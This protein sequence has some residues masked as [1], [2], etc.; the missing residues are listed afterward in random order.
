MRR[1][2]PELDGV[3][4]ALD[5]GRKTGFALGEPGACPVL[6]TITLSREFDIP[7][8]VF[9]RAVRWF[10]KIFVNA[11]PRP[12]A[13]I[14]EQPIPPSNMWGATNFAATTILLGLFAIFVGTA[15]AHNVRVVEAPVR[16]WRKYFLGN[17]DLKREEAKL[18]ASRLCRKLE[19]DAVDDNA[20]EAAGIWAWGC[21][22][23][24]PSKIKRRVEPLFAGK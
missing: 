22:Q 16:T 15:R 7:A 2:I 8:D 10:D 11:K 1:G 4:L 12:V 17:G 18:A 14:V 24:A 20:A 9:P 21:T 13:V 6:N 3:V 19:W 5:Q 23:V